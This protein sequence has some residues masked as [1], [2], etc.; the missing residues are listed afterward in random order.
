[1]D[2]VLMRQFEDYLK[3]KKITSEQT[4]AKP[5]TN[6]TSSKQ[7]GNSIVKRRKRSI[8]P[9]IAFT[10]SKEEASCRNF[11]LIFVNIVS[12]ELYLNFDNLVKYKIFQLQFKEHAMAF[13]KAIYPGASGS[14][15]DMAKM[16]AL[17]E[18]EPNDLIA[19]VKHKKYITN[20][21]LKH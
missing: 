19:G 1:M 20:R 17:P 4:S 12:D 7:S 15:V 2:V 10:L 5:S 9:K 21:I 18:I 13:L 14:P 6:S 3:S 8:E 16:M 11:N